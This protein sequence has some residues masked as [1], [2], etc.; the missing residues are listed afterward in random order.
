MSTRSEKK[1]ALLA[2]VAL[3]G[4]D[5]AAAAAAPITKV[6]QGKRGNVQPIRKA[7][8]AA[9]A[10]L[11]KAKAK[12]TGTKRKPMTTATL[13]DM[14]PAVARILDDGA[15]LDADADRNC[16]LIVFKIS[17][18]YSKLRQ[19]SGNVSNVV[20]VS[21]MFSASKRTLEKAGRDFI[22]DLCAAW[23][24]PKVQRTGK[25][26]TQADFNYY[27]SRAKKIKR[28]AEVFMAIRGTSVASNVEALSIWDTKTETLNVPLAAFIP[29]TPKGE[30]RFTFTDPLYQST[31]HTKLNGA[32]YDLV[33]HI[34]VDGVRTPKR[35]GGAFTMT[36]LHTRFWTKPKAAKQGTTAT[37]PQGAD[38]NKEGELSAKQRKAA[39]SKASL[40]E[41]LPYAVS[42][43]D[44]DRKAWP[45]LDDVNKDKNKQIMHQLG[46]LSTYYGELS[47]E[48]TRRS[49][50]RAAERAAIAA[51]RGKP[52]KMGA[53]VTDTPIATPTKAAP[54]EDI[55]SI[56]DAA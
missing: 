24:G 32:A 47:A 10:K 55:T 43:L 53:P 40:F 21:S 1:A 22:S 38:Q 50:A 2:S 41:L 26:T 35:D 56:A 48:A 18:A 52:F 51:K 16:Q 25:T 37:A 7:T 15:K 19:S 5:I 9:V 36:H 33:R 11:N 20:A 39:F 13:D 49:E 42:D 23:I 46:L 31:T 29:T 3:Q 4:A 34:M 44:A 28:A 17:D 54:I 30:E 45:S 14:K 8:K 12:A 6:A 27:N